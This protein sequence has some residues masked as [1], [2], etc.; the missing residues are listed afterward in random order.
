L[1]AV[2][3]GA[4][5]LVGFMGAGKT[6]AARA[7]AEALGVGAVD[8]DELLEAR[9]GMPIARFFDER[10]EAAF[11]AEEEAA[12]VELLERSDPAVI[13]LGGGAV[14]SPAVREALGAHRVLWLD[15][16]VEQAWAR[17]AGQDRPLARDRERF[18]SLHAERLPLYEAVADALVPAAAVDRALAALVAWAG[19]PPGT[20]LVWAT[21]PSAEYPVFAGEGL[22]EAGF[23][24]VEGRRFLVTDG[25]VARWYAGLLKPTMGTAMVMPGEASKTVAHAE[26]VWTEMANAG[27]T[28]D[29]HVTA[30]GGGVVGDLAG[31]CAATYQRGVRLVG[32]PTTLVAQ[33][34]SAY[35]GK[36]GVDLVEA[37][38]YVGAYH[39]PAAVITDPATLR[40]LPA[41]EL[42]AGYAEVVKT[43][44]IAG[45]ELWERV[46]TRA[47][48]GT[49]LDTIVA[50]ART[51]LAVVAADE[52]DAGERQVLN[53]GHTVAHAIETTTG[54]TR[55]RH[56]EAVGLGLLAALRLSGQDELRQEVAALLHRHGLP[57]HLDDDV[58]LEA[59]ELATARDKKRRG[60]APVP[61]VLIAAPGNVSHG[62]PVDPAALRAALRELAP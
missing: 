43:A 5:V 29:D 2:T 16:S 56:G 44:L 32:V 51:K 24:P 59:V 9:L 61:F 39:H 4:L 57:L 27:V 22:V 11:R 37:K 53:L 18:A 21:S 3:S 14:A 13:A 17:A 33:V 41:E 10:G 20:Q 55:Y 30:L 40:T 52:R 42:A 35:G 49:D 58:D 48:D 50:C 36:T 28:R 38:N 60:E 62:N 12:V 23:Y 25:Q 15:V 31:F 6:T 34:D 47:T 46:R 54:Y 26:I 8:A 7:V 19:S 1:A 45:G